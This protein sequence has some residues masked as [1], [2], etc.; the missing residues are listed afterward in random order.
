MPVS[1]PV[2]RKRLWP[3]LEASDVSRELIVRQRLEVQQAV[4]E[5][6]AMGTELAGTV[7]PAVAPAVA[8]SETEAATAADDE[9]EDILGFALADSADAAA[10]ALA[11]ADTEEEEEETASH[12]TTSSGGS[13]PS[14]FTMPVSPGHSNNSTVASDSDSD[15]ST[16]LPP[17]IIHIPRAVFDAANAAVAAAAAGPPLSPFAAFLQEQPN[18]TWTAPLTPVLPTGQYGAPIVIPDDDDDNGN[19]ADTEAET[20]GDS[21]SATSSQATNADA[22]PVFARS[23]HDSLTAVHGSDTEHESLSDIE[24]S[25]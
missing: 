1:Q 15:A 12:N 23:R 7:S 20:D 3:T 22:D 13:L 14:G 8:V 11:D 6:V 4:D 18:P 5:V 25:Q 19:E 17:L 9:D 10:Q 16:A 2:H 24:M 21:A